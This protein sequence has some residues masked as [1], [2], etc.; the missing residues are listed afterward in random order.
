MQ[1]VIRTKS[2]GNVVVIGFEGKCDAG[3]L[4]EWLLQFFK[5]STRTRP[6]GVQMLALGDEDIRQAAI[7]AQD[8]VLR[9]PNLGQVTRKMALFGGR[10]DRFVVMYKG[11]AAQYPTGDK[12]PTN[13]PVSVR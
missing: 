5:A 4:K 12:L 11:V 13:S 1:Y 8:Y 9:L 10:I 6:S 3:I 2:T 7:A